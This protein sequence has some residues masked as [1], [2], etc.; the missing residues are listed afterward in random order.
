MFIGEPER[1]WANPPHHNNFFE[2][3]RT[4]RP[5]IAD[6]EQGFR[7]TATVLLA[8]IALKVRR[9]LNWD[10]EA[11]RFLNDEATNRYLRRAYRAP[12]HL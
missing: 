3:V 2:S 8:G 5:P 6:I 12:W 4:R 7:A 11:E 10:G 9:K 1:S